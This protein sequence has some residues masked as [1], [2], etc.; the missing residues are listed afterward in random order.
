[1]SVSENIVRLSREHDSRIREDRRVIH[2]HPGV[3]ME[4]EETASFVAKTLE[5]MGLN[6]CRGVGGTGVVALLEGRETG[7]VVGLRAD[8]DALQIQEQTGLPFASE[9]PGIMHACGHDTHTAML[10]G[11]ARILSALKETIRGTVKFVFQPAEECAPTG[12]APAMIA[13]G[14]LENPAVDAMVALHVWPDLPTGKVGIK[15]GPIMGASDRLDLTVRGCSAHGSTPEQGVDAVVVAAQVITALQTVVSRSVNATEAVV[16][17][18][19]TVHGGYRYNVLAD[20]VRLEGTLRTLSP[21]VRDVLPGKIDTLA[22]GVCRGM[23]GDCEMHYERGYAPTI[24][25]PETVSVVRGSIANVLGERGILEIEKPTLGGEDFSF[26][27]SRVPSVFLWLGC[28]PEEIAP[29]DFPPLH[30]PRFVP[31]ESCFSI[32]AAVLAQAAW[33]LLKKLGGGVSA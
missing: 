27:A 25:H 12:G 32:G 20:E 19:G 5:E 10:L 4:V 30:N 21:D 15:T 23:G 24:N 18:F 33:D 8:M 31:D 16:L 13:D 29:E 22:R 1:M 28:R 14:V 11:A 3:G 2:R 17:T 6:V 26:F 9:I 7:P